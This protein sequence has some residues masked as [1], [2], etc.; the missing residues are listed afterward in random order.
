MTLTKIFF[1]AD[2]YRVS[3]HCVFCC[4]ITQPHPELWWLLP[5]CTTKTLVSGCN[6]LIYSSIFFVFFFVWFGWHFQV[7]LRG[8]F[9]ASDMS[10]GALIWDLFRLGF[11]SWLAASLSMHCSVATHNRNRRQPLLRCAGVTRELWVTTPCLL[12]HCFANC[13]TC[14]HSSRWKCEKAYLV[15]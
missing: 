1:V 3:S 8:N 4:K 11:G 9:R 12:K 13:F 5:A 14:C 15:R 10:L 6:L 7:L 2:T